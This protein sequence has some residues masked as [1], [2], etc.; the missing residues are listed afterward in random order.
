MEIIMM[1]TPYKTR[2]ANLNSWM[3]NENIDAV[4]I[5]DAEGRRSANLAYLSGMPSDAVLIIFSDGESVLLP[6]DEILA[7]K[8]ATAGRI[9]GYSEYE[10]NPVKAVS[11][12]C[13]DKLSAGR[14]ELSSQTPHLL[15]SEISDS[16]PGF[17]IEC[18]IDGA[19]ER[20]LQMR[21]VKDEAET[22]I[23]LEA[24]KL[25]NRMIDAICAGFESGEIKTELD[26]ALFIEAES[27]RLGAEGPSFETLA[28]GAS[29]S[30]GI[31]AFPSF[32]AGPI[33][34]TAEGSSGGLS[35]ID[36]G[37]KY[38]GYCTDITMTIC[39]GTLSEK[40]E[41]MVRLVQEAYELAA[42]AAVSGISAAKLAGLVDEH[43]T[44]SGYSMPHGLGHGV[45]LDVH[46]DPG[47]KNKDIYNRPITPGMIFTIEPGLYDAEAG[48]VRLEDDFLMTDSGAVAI[49]SSRILRLP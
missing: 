39:R 38:K 10:R 24:G 8:M 40:Q 47:I 12:L 9:I 3:V 34:D 21:A 25:T 48:G 15:Y 19:A 26:A 5:E 2:I 46:E 14:I 29:R 42:K 41:L 23:Y 32:T 7:G 43:F 36:C 4:V 22:E 44:A 35:I 13:K 28:A 20:L 49:T 16:L 17:E 18:R 37:L 33:G 30:W 1:N 6:W 31:H 27:R 45:G 11:E